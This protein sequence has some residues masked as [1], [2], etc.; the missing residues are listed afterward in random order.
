MNGLYPEGISAMLDSTASVHSYNLRGSSNNIFIPK[1]RTEAGKP[2]FSY[3]GAV[4]W[5]SPPSDLRN[6]RNL[7]SFKDNFIN[8]SFN[9][10]Q[11]QLYSQFSASYLLKYT[12]TIIIL[13]CSN[14]LA[15]RKFNTYTK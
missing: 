7:K 14:S 8:Y 5:N 11:Q 12:K 6:Q 1:P 10:R 2:V 9:K 15:L 4:L 3:R 13:D